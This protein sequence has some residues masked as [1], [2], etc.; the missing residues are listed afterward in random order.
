MTMVVQ[1]LI[2]G[3]AYG[4]IYALVGIEYTLVW[5][6]SGLLNFSH[7]RLITL[8]AYIFGGS[9]IIRL[10]LQ[11]PVA[12]ILSLAIMGAVGRGTGRG[13]VQS[14]AQHALEHFRHHRHGYPFQDYC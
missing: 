11:Y 6:S 9:M 13:R 14:P 8:G 10:N 12:I 4:L 1:L 3:I 5:N 2:S 7:D